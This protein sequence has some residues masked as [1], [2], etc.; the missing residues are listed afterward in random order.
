MTTR[1]PGSGMQKI[2]E[3]P[4]IELGTAT[5]QIAVIAVVTIAPKYSHGESN[6]DLTLRKGVCFPLHH[7]SKPSRTGVE[8]VACD[9]QSQMLPIHQRDSV[10][11]LRS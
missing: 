11:W 7:E 10:G 5:C 1:L 3:P 2:M 6:P 9:R 4:R 8:P